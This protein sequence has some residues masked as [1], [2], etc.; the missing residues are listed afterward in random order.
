VDPLEHR[1]REGLRDDGWRVQVAPDALQRVHAGATRRRQRRATIRNVAAAA[2]LVAGGAGGIG[3]AVNTDSPITTAFRSG[4][5]SAA[6][7]GGS[8]EEDSALSSDQAR[9]QG[10]T[11]KAAPQED[12]SPPP[13]RTD[14]QPGTLVAGPVPAGFSP[15]SM[16]ATSPDAYWLLGN[17]ETAGQGAAVVATMDGGS[18][19]THAGGFDATVVHGT[20]DVTASTVR[21]L[22]FATGGRDG[23]AYGGG[24]WSTHDAGTTFTRVTTGPASGLVERLETAGGATYALARDGAAWSLWQTPAGGDAWQPLDA[25]LHQPGALAV[26]SDLVAVTDHADGETYALVSTDGGTTFTRRPTPCSADLGAGDLSATL[27]GLWLTCAT[28]TSATV[29][30]STDDAATWTKVPTDSPAISATA[31]EV[32]AR[33]GAQAIVATPGKALLVGPGGAT[34]TPVPGLAAPTFAGFTTSK[35][36]Y[37]LDVEG[38]LFRSTDGG[39]TWALVRVD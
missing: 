29:H 33:G 18:T 20:N 4:A 2:V 28:G 37:I 21:G 15:V 26:T 1:L 24:L 14:A 35:V 17:G 6:Q 3:Y 16:T 39:S 8:V 23:W 22:R 32:G 13:E 11:S 36:G 19:F 30:V 12:A 31:S 5:D 27:D 34:S 25:D 7:G 9:E 38:Q 10:D